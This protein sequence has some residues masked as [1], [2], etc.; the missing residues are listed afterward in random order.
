MPEPIAVS[1]PLLNPN[2]RD[3]Q[4]TALHVA[5]GAAVDA[6]DLLCTLETTKSAVEVTA[7]RAGH[8]VALRAAEGD[9]V[10][11]G[12]TLCWVADDPAWVPPGAEQGAADGG[13]GIPDGL[14]MTAPA[15]AAAREAGLDL[16]SLP[17]GELI[18]E[19]WVRREI[20]ARS[21][22][23]A[24]GLPKSFDPQ[25]VVIYGGGGHG[26][27]LIDLIR[28]LGD[29]P[30]AGVIDDGMPAGEQLMGLTVLGGAEVLPELMA[31]GLQLAVNAVGGVGDVSSRVRVFERIL[32]AGLTCPTMV[33]PTA[34]V[35][36]SAKLAAG[37]QVFPHAYVGS[38]VEV[39][40]GA[41]IN[42]AAVVSHDCS[43]EDYVNIAPGAL[44]AGGVRI[45]ER[46]LVGM[47]VTVNLNVTIGPGALIG[48][49]AVVKRDVPAET[50]V[51]AGAVWP[52]R[53]D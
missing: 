52:P 27:S 28:L 16:G 32:A 30:L 45:G 15:L 17:A 7:P 9:L 36:P 20:A 34:F 10:H 14:R 51:H 23:E 4:I 19:A 42:T 53:P 31:R 6:G 5:A 37:V 11:T 8:V 35:E 50:V 48:N 13:A 1:V 47:G 41:I 2:E 21:A 40:F 25:A 24:P 38:E 49:S 12:S 3:A 33:H 39:G 43:L 18:T 26:K 22:G 44:L 46:T 29:H